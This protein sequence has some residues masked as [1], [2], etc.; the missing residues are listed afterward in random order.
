MTSPAPEM[1]LFTQPRRETVWKLKIS[2]LL[3][4]H[5]C[6][7]RGPQALIR[8]LGGH[9]I[10]TLLSLRLEIAIFQTV[11]LERVLQT[12]IWGAR[13]VQM[14]HAAR[15]NLRSMMRLMAP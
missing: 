13:Q 10:H 2:S 4:S 3:G 7:K 8:R 6:S 1:T 5:E 14:L 9:Q 15:A 11:S 12:R